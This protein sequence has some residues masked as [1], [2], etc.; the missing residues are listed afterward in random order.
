MQN[1]HEKNAFFVDKKL[2]LYWQVKV[3]PISCVKTAFIANEGLYQ[4]KVMPF[5]LMN[6]RAVFQRL[7]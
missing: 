1:L 7:M 4:F 3:H 5:G 6:A 2:V